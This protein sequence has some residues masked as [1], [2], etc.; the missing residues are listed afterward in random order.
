M[1]VP[2]GTTIEVG[3]YTYGEPIV[4]SWYRPR[5]L[6]IGAFC[7][8]GG[9]VTIYLSGNHY[10]TN[11]STFPFYQYFSGYNDPYKERITREDV[12]VGSDVWIGDNV[13]ILPG[14]FI[15]NGCVLGAYSVVRGYVAPYSIMTGNPGVVKK[16]RFRD[17][18]INALMR[19]EWWN[20]PDEKI[21][22]NIGLLMSPNVQGLI[23]KHENFKED[24]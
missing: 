6:H 4:K 15:E 21:R 17:D 7:S 11:V 23:D 20:W 1:K 16:R 3:K 14:A 9:D 22:E 24:V 19:I 10:I 18:Q 12:Y 5:H 2:E 13:V 8:I